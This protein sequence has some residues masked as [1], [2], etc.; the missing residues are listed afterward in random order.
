MSPINR[1]NESYKS[2]KFFSA[3]QFLYQNTTTQKTQPPRTHGRKRLLAASKP[4][5]PGG[6]PISSPGSFTTASA[7][8]ACCPCNPSVSAQPQ[9]KAVSQSHQHNPLYVYREWKTTLLKHSRAVTARS[10]AFCTEKQSNR[11]T[12]EPPVPPQLRKPSPKHSSATGQA[13]RGRSYSALA[14]ISVLLQRPPF[15]RPTPKEGITERRG[16]PHPNPDPNQ[17]TPQLPFCLNHSTSAKRYKWDPKF[18]GKK[19][20]LETYCSCS[21]H[22]PDQTLLSAL[23]FKHKQTSCKKYRLWAP[24]RKGG[25]AWGRIIKKVLIVCGK[26]SGNI[27]AH[28]ELNHCM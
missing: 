10:A 22:S 2:E 17:K 26:A 19:I 11:T 7:A 25:A 6:S 12:A 20:L 4:T 21:R 5:P 15:C 16:T 28:Q 14:R 24:R 3:T 9:D 27:S 1:E 13:C 23:F 8:S 18:R